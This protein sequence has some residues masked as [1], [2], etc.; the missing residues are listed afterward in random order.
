MIKIIIMIL[1]LLGL[2]LETPEFSSKEM[3]VVLNDGDHPVTLITEA[4]EEEHQISVVDG[5]VEHNFFARD[6]E[7]GESQT[8][9]MQDGKKLTVRYEDG[10]FFVELDGESI[11]HKA[12]KPSGF[13][14]TESDSAVRKMITIHRDS[15]SDEA[16]QPTTSIRILSVNGE[17]E[18]DLNALLSNLKGLEGLENLIK[19]DVE[20]DMDGSGKRVITIIA[21]DES[22]EW[23]EG[24]PI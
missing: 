3:I 21:D 24:D 22:E 6:F 16:S 9:V 4:N 13:L 18:V 10:D 8:V 19:V 5:D 1:C 23:E 11:L 7:D 14:F 12:F 15:P 20:H 17:Q 2:G